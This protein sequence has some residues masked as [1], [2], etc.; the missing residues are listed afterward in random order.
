M[1]EVPDA[2]RN[3]VRAAGAEDWLE[4]LPA[5]ITTLEADWSISVG[6]PYTGGS[7]AYVAEAT[8]ADGASAIL[9]VLVPGLGNE[10]SNE[11]TVLRIV[12]GE[13][14]P[15]L[16]RHDADRGALLMERLG[17]PMFEL[18][19]P[20]SRRLE[21][22][23]DTAA[24][25]WRP[26][27]D[28]GLPTGAEKARSLADFIV[29]LWEELDHPCSE[30]AIEHALVS[31]G[32]RE[33]AHRDEKAVLVHGDVHQLNALQS[34][35]GF[36]LIDPH[37]LLAEAEYD[38]GVLMRGDPVEL[39]AGDPLERA[40]WLAARTGLDPVATWEWG[41]VERVKTALLCTQIHLQPLGRDTLR[42][43]E[44]VAGVSMP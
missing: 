12:G 42:A 35:G 11:A 34:D 41:V 21:I 23:C 31:A 24:G 9:K 32:R 7:G 18:G 44:A 10:S 30:E 38:L 43:A 33:R 15:A 28:C 26:A 5:L 40:R 25:I 37:G 14:C 6:R 20:L 29:R 36:K 16:Y 3:M 27:P 4:R 1:I 2:V 13:G 39:I 22:L 17:Q 8:R 19:L